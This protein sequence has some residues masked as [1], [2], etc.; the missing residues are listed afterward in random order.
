MG[1]H[2]RK[3]KRHIK[4]SNTL[5]KRDGII[6]T[7]FVKRNVP[8]RRFFAVKTKRPEVCTSGRMNENRIKPTAAVQYSG[9]ICGCLSF[10]SGRSVIIAS[11]TSIKPAMLAAFCKAERVTLVGSMIPACTRSS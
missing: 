11:V 3:F 7:D 9:G 10:F 4:E 5:V 1:S 8:T 6:E 2:Y